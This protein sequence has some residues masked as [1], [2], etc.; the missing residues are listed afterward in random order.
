MFKNLGSLNAFFSS[1]L[2]SVMHTIETFTQSLI[3][4]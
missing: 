2:L 3:T 4:K 1:V